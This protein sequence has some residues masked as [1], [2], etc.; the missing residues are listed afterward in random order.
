ML[1]K[2]PSSGKCHVSKASNMVCIPGTIVIFLREMLN[3]PDVAV[4]SA[5]QQRDL[6]AEDMGSGLSW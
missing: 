4:L 6:Q 2:V 5:V 1:P 3:V